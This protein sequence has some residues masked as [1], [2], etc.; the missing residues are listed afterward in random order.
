MFAFISKESR[1]AVQ[2]R[3]ADLRSWSARHVI[4]RLRTFFSFVVNKEKQ[5]IFYDRTTKAN[6]INIIFKITVFTS[7]IWTFP[8]KILVLIKSIH[9]T[10]KLVATR[11]GNCVD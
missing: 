8:Y 6:T 4:Y 2:R 1:Q 3:S 10:M 9:R 5:F 11:F 7:V